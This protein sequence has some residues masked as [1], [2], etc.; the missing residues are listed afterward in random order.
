MASYIL[1]N[2]LAYGADWSRLVLGGAPPSSPRDRAEGA[3]ARTECG[4]HLRIQYESP[5][6]SFDTSL[7]DEDGR[8]IPEN[9]APPAAPPPTPAEDAPSLACLL[10]TCSFYDHM[11]HVWRWDWGPEEAGGAGPQGAA[12]GQDPAGTIVNKAHQEVKPAA[13]LTQ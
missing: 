4:G 6:A 8:Y 9:S 1:H 11:L 5:T 7:E 10:A 12:G 13:H 2:S 3:G